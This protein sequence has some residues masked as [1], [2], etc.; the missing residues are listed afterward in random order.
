L[1]IKSL[2]TNIKHETGLTAL[3]YWLRRYPELL[4]RLPESFVLK[5]CELILKNN[6]FQFDNINYIQKTGTAMGTKFAP[7]Y[8]TLTLGYLEEIFFENIKG[9]LGLEKCS[10]IKNNYYRYLDDVFVICNNTVANDIM[11]TEHLNRLDPELEFICDQKGKEVTFLDIKI[12]KNN[13]NTVETD[14][15]Y[16]ETDSKQYLNYNSNHPRYVKNNI[17][18]NLARRICTIVSNPELKLKRLKEL[19]RFLRECSFPDNI[20]IQGIEKSLNLSQGELRNQSPKR[21]ENDTNRTLI[22]FITTHTP[23][24]NNNYNVI[25][26]TVELLE[27]SPS[28]GGHFKN[29][30]ILNSKRQPPN[31]KKML[32]SASFGKTERVGEIKKCGDN[33]CILCTHLIEG[34][35]FYFKSSNKHFYIKSNMDCNTK[36]CIYAMLCPECGQSYI[37]ETKDFRLRTNLHRQ[38]INQRSDI[39]VSKHLHDCGGRNCKIMPIFKMKTSSE[40]DRKQKESKYIKDFKPDLNIK[41]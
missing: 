6:T 14:I 23:N 5:G 25:Q 11:I 39:L 8:A 29:I 2:Y 31:L 35:S 37:G 16:K 40:E 18:Y 33:K 41:L 22:P 32:T 13:V 1:D 28:L 10:Y 36:Y 19:T 17:P 12:M 34:K 38:H 24:L 15:F 30:K 20:I 7:C 21:K 4:D 26:K 27:A 9:E 3:K